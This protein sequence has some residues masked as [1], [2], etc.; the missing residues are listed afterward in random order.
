MSNRAAALYVGRD[1]AEAVMGRSWRCVQ[2]LAAELGVKPRKVGRIA[3]YLASE[4]VAAIERRSTGGSS[5]E[6][7]TAADELAEMRERVRRAG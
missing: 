1:N 6:D 7:R 5:N 4:L 3:L 2:D